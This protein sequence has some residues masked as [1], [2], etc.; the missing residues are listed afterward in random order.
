MKGIADSQD[1]TRCQGVWGAT[2][3]VVQTA[4][5]VEVMVALA[6]TA[7]SPRARRRG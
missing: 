6:T 3:V 4:E 7:D 5:E 2:V 1:G